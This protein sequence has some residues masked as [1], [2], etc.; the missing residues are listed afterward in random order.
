[1]TRSQRAVAVPATED[2][3][4][5]LL[6]ARAMTPAPSALPL[7]AQ[8]GAPRAGIPFMALVDTLEMCS[9]P[10][11]TAAQRR[12]LVGDL[13]RRAG[14]DARERLALYRRETPLFFFFFWAH[15]RTQPP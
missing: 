7:H 2:E 11:G 10:G 12:E 9:Q 8:P 3:E 14:D 15:E 13:L 5:A 1:M 4:R 6:L